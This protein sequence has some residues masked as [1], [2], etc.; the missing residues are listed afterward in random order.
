MKIPEDKEFDELVE[1]FRKIAKDENEMIQLLGE[2]VLKR[3]LQFASPNSNKME[4]LSIEEPSS[5][6]LGNKQKFSETENEEYHD[7][8]QQIN[9]AAATPEAISKKA[10]LLK[11]KSLKKPSVSGKK[12]PSFT[13]HSWYPQPELPTEV[14]NVIE[15]LGG[16][17]AK[18]VIEKEV[19]G[20]DLHPH[21]DRIS[22]PK[23]QVRVEFL[24][25]QERNEIENNDGIRVRVIEPCLRETI[26]SLRQWQLRSSISY[27][28]NGGWKYVAA[29]AENQLKVKDKVQVWSFRVNGE[30]RLAVVKLPRGNLE[31]GQDSNDSQTTEDEVKDEDEDEAG[32]SASPSKEGKAPESQKI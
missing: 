29:R 8:H 14:K 26:L 11:E 30:L 21:H 17:D 15:R 22:I 6:T 1:K 27:V 13:Q 2:E 19:Y 5:S 12:R 18:L 31:G 9:T 20:T 28:L 25:D 3:F 4:K 10:R 7:H 32:P 24:N 23:N 16:S